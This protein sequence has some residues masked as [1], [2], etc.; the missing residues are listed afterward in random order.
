MA[1]FL[2]APKELKAVTE[3]M[4]V[5]ARMEAASFMVVV[6]WVIYWFR[7]DAN[8]ERNMRRKARRRRRRMLMA[9]TAHTTAVVATSSG[10]VVWVVREI[11]DSIVHRGFLCLWCVVS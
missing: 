9:N 8:C 2:G 11:A 7:V 1:D 5:R 3:D 6:V 4:L 10:Q